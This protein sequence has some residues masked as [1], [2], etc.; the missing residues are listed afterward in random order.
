MTKKEIKAYAE[1][2]LAGQGN[3]VDLGSA[4]P[5]VIGGILDLI[6]MAE[7]VSHADLKTQVSAGKLIPGA[8]YRITDY[9]ATTAQPG[10]RS[11]G[12]P[13]DII[14]VAVDEK[15]LS[16][17]AYA[18][19]H[20]G[21]EYFKGFALTAWEIKYTIENDDKYVWALTDK[22]VDADDNVY[23]RRPKFD[24]SVEDVKFH[25]Y[26]D[27]ANGRL[28]WFTEEIQQA[29]TFALYYKDGD[30]FA[31]DGDVEIVTFEKST[32]KGV[33]YYMKDE[34][35]N[36]R[37][38]DFKGIQ[39]LRDTDWCDDHTAFTDEVLLGESKDW[40]LYPFTWI[41]EDGTV[42]DQ[43]L[44]ANT[45]V[46]K[47]D[48]GRIVGCID[49]TVGMCDAN[50]IYGIEGLFAIDRNVFVSSYDYDGGFYYG[51]YGNHFGTNCFNNTFGNG[52]YGNTFGNNTDDI[53]NV[54]VLNGVGGKTLA[55]VSN[56]SYS[57]FAGIT[58]AG[59]LR[60]WN[61]ADE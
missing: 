20:D 33:I 13:F 44:I 57:Q 51:C 36:V 53:R 40:W 50:S 6:P 9:V 26:W 56:A 45:G 16:E 5:V 1:R 10:T 18:V 35:G 39:I 58:T 17:K 43:S 30:D 42:Q 54:N 37:H 2:C 12:H 3:Q 55:F 27:F 23:L 24:A 28:V 61:P 60:I 59:N 41:T 7:S 25:A 11:A 34:F 8:L 19:Q 4:L 32:G 46:L 22:I 15:T 52:C 29:G 47:N 31:T 48:E 38:F 14:V 49:N 21:D